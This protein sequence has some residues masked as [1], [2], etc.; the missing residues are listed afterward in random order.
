MYGFRIIIAQEMLK[1][2]NSH[3]RIL[4][5]KE[6]NDVGEGSLEEIASAG[7]ESFVMNP[8]Y[9]FMRIAR[10]DDFLDVAC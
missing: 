1:F 3:F 10:Y 7:L 6:R 9:S 8:N 2:A 5:Q 4:T